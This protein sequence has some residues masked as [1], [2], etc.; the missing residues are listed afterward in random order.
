MEAI[1]KRTLFFSAV[2]L[3]IFGAGSTAS[4][5]SIEDVNIWRTQLKIHTCDLN[6]AGTDSHVSVVLNDFQGTSFYLHNPKDKI[7]N[8]TDTFDIL[9]PEVTQIRDLT[10]LTLEIHGS[11]RWCFDRLE[12]LVNANPGGAGGNVY[13]VPIFVS[14]QTVWL[15]RTN[16]P[17]RFTRSGAA[18]RGDANWTDFVGSLISKLP[19][20]IKRAQIESMV[21]GIVGDVMA[22]DPDAQWG[23]L[24]GSS[25]VELTPPTTLSGVLLPARVDLD[26]E[27]QS[28]FEK[29]IDVDFTLRAKCTNLGSGIAIEFSA[30]D[31]DADLFELFPAFDTLL[32]TIDF[33]LSASFVVNGVLACPS[34]MGFDYQGDWTWF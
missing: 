24:N 8:Q 25:Y 27:R 32:P 3:A 15:D 9:I 14:T 1:M 7:R 22:R 30:T 2:A 28:F 31:F 13:A 11:D 19:R 6:N 29:N 20:R 5:A 10:Q 21:T 4:A 18:L 12:L 23:G 34:K 26:V 33:G 16:G 17:T